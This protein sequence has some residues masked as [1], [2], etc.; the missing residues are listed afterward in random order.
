MATV[1][2]LEMDFMTELSKLQRLRVY[3]AKPALTAAQISTAMDSI[4]S[5]NIFNTSGGELISKSGARM[6]TK[7]TDE[8]ELV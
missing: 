5:E 6:V 1:V 3:N 4:I 7:E 2:T 8:F